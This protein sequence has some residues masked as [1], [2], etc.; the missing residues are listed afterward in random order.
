MG[1]GR[2]KS[3]RSTRLLNQAAGLRN[4]VSSVTV[5]SAHTR[6]VIGVQRISSTC[7]STPGAAEDTATTAVRHACILWLS[8]RLPGTTAS[9]AHRTD[10]PEARR[11]VRGSL[12][13]T[14]ANSIGYT[15]GDGFPIVS[16][17]ELGARMGE[18]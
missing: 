9:P 10:P 18:P 8:H 4:D 15:M 6:R 16:D 3:S 17:A 12:G 1:A 11:D 13:R 14:S 7:K 5:A 2:G